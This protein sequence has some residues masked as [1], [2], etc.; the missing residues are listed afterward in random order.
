MQ[1]AEQAAPQCPLLL[2]L[3]RKDTTRLLEVYVKRSLSVNDGSLPQRKPWT[4]AQKWVTL[5]KG[6]QAVRRSSSDSSAHLGSN[7]LASFKSSPTEVPSSA[8]LVG[9]KEQE[10]KPG[11]TRKDA[12]RDKKSST[13]KRF[14]GLFSKKRGE[15][16]EAREHSAESA[17]ACLPPDSPP[18]SLLDSSPDTAS[19][20]VSCLSV[21]NPFGGDQGS[22]RSGKSLKKRRSLLKLSFRSRDTD[23][24]RTQRE[25]SF[26]L[27]PGPSDEAVVCVEPSSTYYEKVSEELE[28]IVK[29]VKDSPSDEDH[30]TFAESVQKRASMVAAED[31][32]CIEKIISLLKQQG[33]AIDVKI[34]DNVK[35]S[36]FF[37]SLSYRDFQQL[38]D[39]YV[40]E[41][42]PSQ[43]PQD[44]AAPE[45]LKF[46]FTLDFTAKVAGLANQAVSRIMGFGNQYLQDRF[47][48]M[49]KAHVL[50]SRA[51]VAQSFSGPD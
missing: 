32:E 1:P 42:I 34:K 8:P 37:Q 18:D 17:G 46:A 23:T 2:S 12:K 47:T 14:L 19:P 27:L 21:P 28:R 26:R 33:D 11:R 25:P 20:P 24:T 13:W 29:E 10:K 51:E 44:T 7:K 30:A 16:K 4:K 15:E 22:P 45:L 6:R 31:E 43:L 3:G 36:S 50:T 41:E 35:V 9:A 49:S 5:A 39:R 40:E 48:Q 38:A